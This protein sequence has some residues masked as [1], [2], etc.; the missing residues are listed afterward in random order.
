MEATDL[1]ELDSTVDT[2]GLGTGQFTRTTPSVIADVESQRLNGEYSLVRSFA[3]AAARLLVL[4]DD[5]PTDIE[6]GRMRHVTRR[7]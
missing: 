7:S 3:A 2:Q 5:S 1:P 4:L 6:V